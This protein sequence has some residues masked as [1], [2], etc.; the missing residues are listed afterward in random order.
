[1]RAAVGVEAE[2]RFDAA[3]PDGPPRKLCDTSL[4]RGLGWRPEIALPDGLRRTVAEF[5]AEAAS[6]ALRG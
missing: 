3:M 4:I 2:L 6:G 5:R 1:M